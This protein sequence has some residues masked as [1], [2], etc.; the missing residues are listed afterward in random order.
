MQFIILIVTIFQPPTNFYT[1]FFTILD[2]IYEKSCRKFVYAIYQF[3][4]LRILPLF[5]NS[6]LNQ[7]KELAL[8]NWNLLRFFRFNR[9]VVYGWKNI[10]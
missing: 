1:I 7:S 10:A 8:Y 9:A 6:K 3:I 2:C 5:D 4:R